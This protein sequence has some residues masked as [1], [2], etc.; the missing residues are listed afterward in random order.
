M[1]EHNIICFEASDNNIRLTE[2][3]SGLGIQLDTRCAGLGKCGGCTI[4]LLEGELVNIETGKTVSIPQKLFACIHT[5][6]SSSPA[7]IR[8]PQRSIISAKS[9]AVDKFKIS[10]N[11]PKIKQQLNTDKKYS[12]AIDV[13]T[14]TVAVMLVNLETQTICATATSF[15]NQIRYGDNVL[16]RIRHCQSDSAMTGVLQKTINIQ[17]IIPLLD[18]LLQQEE[19]FYDHLQDIIISGNTTMQHLCA[20]INPQGIGVSPFTPVFT[21]TR[22]L[23]FNAIFEHEISTAVRIILLPSISAYLGADILAGALV[24]RTAQS[25]RPVLIVDVGTN[26]EMILNTGSQL[27][28]CSTA[29]GPAFEGSGL[30][31]G[32]RASEGAISHLKIH[33]GIIELDIIGDTDNAVGICGTAYFDFLA[34]C[35]RE[36]LLSTTGRFTEQFKEN[37][38]DYVRHG[39]NGMEICL[40]GISRQDSPRITESDISSLLQ[41][42][43]AVAAGVETMLNRFN[44]KASDLDKV[45]L[46]GGFGL[47][48]NIESALACGLLPEVKIE[49]VELVGNTSLAGAYIAALHHGFIDELSAA[50]AE[51]EIVQLNL[52]EDFEDYY[53]DNMLLPC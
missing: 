9:N 31:S 11:L 32:T 46:A 5:L 42:K 43:A 1:P 4:E 45:Y 23:D 30:T 3:I 12:A 13:G 44:L 52:D 25:S 39:D 47:Y 37:Y 18:R 29:A 8:I 21:E 19:I 26:G 35:L 33:N 40:E 51:I 15:N 2:L 27:A 20:G 6:S 41:A 7:K 50:A 16:T 17:T 53:I 36:N 24:T 38:P 49:Q 22:L 10:Y 48:L 28:G 14:T 34:E